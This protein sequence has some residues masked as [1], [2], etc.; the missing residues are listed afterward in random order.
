MMIPLFTFEDITL[1]VRFS[2]ISC[3]ANNTSHQ[4]SWLLRTASWSGIFALLSFD[5]QLEA[6]RSDRRRERNPTA[7]EVPGAA[8]RSV[9]FS[10]TGISGLPR[11]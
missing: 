2:L 11:S 5:T 8:E 1:A 9:A 4:H 7:V 3:N 10:I 6:I